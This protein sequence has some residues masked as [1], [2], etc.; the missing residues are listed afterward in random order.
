MKRGEIT[1][2]NEAN[3][4]KI[5]IMLK[6]LNGPKIDKKRVQLIFFFK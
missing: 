3:A 2:F 6:T 1:Y 5:S 4:G